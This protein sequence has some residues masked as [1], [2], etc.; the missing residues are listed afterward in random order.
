MSNWSNYQQKI[1]P[2]F[3]NVVQALEN[4]YTSQDI[5]FDQFNTQVESQIESDLQS[6]SQDSTFYLEYATSILNYANKVPVEFGTPSTISFYLMEKDKAHYGALQ[7]GLLDQYPDFQNLINEEPETLAQAI[8]GIASQGDFF[9]LFAQMLVGARTAT[10][11]DHFAL[12]YPIYED[13]E[14][15]LLM[16]SIRDASLSNINSFRVFNNLSEGGLASIISDSFGSTVFFNILMGSINNRAKVIYSQYGEGNPS[17]DLWDVYLSTFPEE[18]RTAIEFVKESGNFETV[19]QLSVVDFSVLQTLLNEEFFLL[20]APYYLVKSSNVT[21]EHSFSYQFN[22]K[23][24]R[25]GDSLPLSNFN[26]QVIDKNDTEFGDRLITTT[27][28]NLNGYFAVELNVLS[29]LLAPYTLD[30][31]FTSI[32]DGRSYQLQQNFDVSNDGLFTFNVSHDLEDNSAILNELVSYD[33]VVVIPPTLDSFLAT[34]N[35]N[36]LQDVR[37]F[38][39]LSGKET[40]PTGTLSIAQRIDAHSNLELLHVDL[41]KEDYLPV[42][43]HLIDE[44]FDSIPKIIK[45]DRY[46]F[47]KK[48]RVHFSS[49]FKLGQYDAGKIY[50][51]ADGVMSYITTRLN[52]G[53]TDRFKDFENDP[54]LRA[55]LND[56]KSNKCNCEDCKAGTSPLAYLTD[57]I[58]YALKNVSEV[59]LSDTLIDGLTVVNLPNGKKKVTFEGS[60][61]IEV[62]GDEKDMITHVTSST[63]KFTL[64][65]LEAKFKHP[66]AQLPANCDSVNKKVCQ[67]RVCIEVLWTH[68]FNPD[69]VSD[70]NDLLSADKLKEIRLGTYEYLLSEL[71]TSYEEIRKF[72]VSSDEEKANLSQRLGIKE[73]NL[74]EL[75]L[76]YS[77]ENDT[78]GDIKLEELFGYRDTTRNYLTTDEGEDLPNALVNTPKSRIATFKENY[79]RDQFHAGDFPSVPY[80]ALGKAKIDPDIIFPSDFRV[81]DESNPLFALWQKRFDWLNSFASQ[82]KGLKKKVSTFPKSK[83]VKLQVSLAE[84]QALGTFTMTQDDS[85]PVSLTPTD[86]TMNALGT[87]ASFLVEETPPISHMPGSTVSFDGETYELGGEE[88]VDVS[89]SNSE[90]S[91]KKSIFEK[92]QEEYTYTNN[93]GDDFFITPWVSALGPGD[94][95]DEGFMDFLLGNIKNHEHYENTLV[96]IQTNFALNEEQFLRLYDLFDID[97]KAKNDINS[98]RLSAEEIEELIDLTVTSVKNRLTVAW[99]NEED[100]LVGGT[101]PIDTENFWEAEKDLVEGES[102][103]PH[104]VSYFGETASLPLIDPEEINLKDLP[105]WKIGKDAVQL[106]NE[107]QAALETAKVDIRNERLT[108]SESSDLGFSK[109]LDFVYGTDTLTQLNTVANNLSSSD[110][111]ISAAATKEIEDDF[112]MSLEEFTFIVALKSKCDEQDPVNQPSE[113]EWGQ[114]FSTLLG[115]YKFLRLIENWKDDEEAYYLANINKCWKLRKPKLRKWRGGVAVRTQWVNELKTLQRQPIIDPYLITP[116]YMKGLDADDV[117]FSADNRVFQIWDNRRDYLEEKRE[118]LI[119]DLGTTEAFQHINTFLQNELKITANF[120]VNSST[121]V[122]FEDDLTNL[123]ERQDNG[124]SI[125][126]ALKQLGFTRKSF[127]HLF[128]VREL[129]KLDGS[130]L[131]T[132]P[133]REEIANLL[134]NI[135]KRRFFTLWN[136][137]EELD[138]DLKDRYPFALSPDFFMIP[139]PQEFTFPPLKEKEKPVYLFNNKE[140]KK[141]KRTLESKERIW[142]N[143]ADSLERMISDTENR[144][145]IP[146]RDAIIEHISKS[147]GISLE[148]THDFITRNLLIDSKSTS[149]ASTTRVSQAIEA[150]QVLLWGMHN[151]ILLD[152]PNIAQLSLTAPDFDEEWKWLGSYATWRS[153]MFVQLYPENILLPSLK[154]NQSD[155]YQ[156]ALKHLSSVTSIKSAQQVFY[157]YFE[158]LNDVKTMELLGNVRL[159]TKAKVGWRFNFSGV[160][161]SFKRETLPNNM[162]CHF[163]IGRG[164]ETESFYFRETHIDNSTGNIARQS[165][166]I[167]IPHDI[168]G[169]YVGVDF[170]TIGNERNI[171]LFFLED[172]QLMITDYD[173]RKNR[174]TEYRKLEFGNLNSWVR[175]DLDVKEYHIIKNSDGNGRPMIFYYGYDMTQFSNYTGYN[176]TRNYSN[177]K[178]DFTYEVFMMNKEGKADNLMFN[179][180]RFYRTSDNHTINGKVVKLEDRIIK[181]SYKEF[182]PLYAYFDHGFK[183]GN[184]KGGALRVV[185]RDMKQGRVGYFSYFWWGLTYSP[186]FFTGVHQYK[187]DKVHMQLINDNNVLYN[188]LQFVSRSGNIVDSY[189]ADDKFSQGQSGTATLASGRKLERSG[190][191]PDSFASNSFVVNFDEGEKLYFFTKEGENEKIIEF[192][193]QPSALIPT[194]SKHAEQQI[195]GI[196]LNEEYTFDVK[197]QEDIAGGRDRNGRILKKEVSKKSEHCT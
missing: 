89:T 58:N 112:K 10:I 46:D 172:N 74:E 6:I 138:T 49:S 109:T 79:L 124:F 108:Y 100:A 146:T 114:F 175:K 155:Q 152:E 91:G 147:E 161:T 111:T 72:R 137:Q 26:V 123:K 120:Q 158:Y 187:N 94:V 12:S 18:K 134:V 24:L 157:E 163:N 67:V 68:I 86:F 38:G 101:L 8:F 162:N 28:T 22:G 77:E 29:E 81:P 66:F 32:D 110:T 143:N 133:E 113:E 4:Y 48:M 76:P 191:N 154:L 3:R 87:E 62:E 141:W 168:K 52:Q 104:N 145:L 128:E 166:W 64:N 195:L 167:K 185:F 174:W 69:T 78:I 164:N 25:T 54:D 60:D 1:S 142:K 177:L 37:D 119:N 170:C 186:H 50:E 71:G 156:K 190:F 5:S 116:A 173:F 151:N 23:L 31:K 169:K 43:K 27:S 65:E 102:P 188:N 16:N 196:P 179:Y 194:Y 42:S 35:L 117:V 180:D 70:S 92:I 149:C 30:Y 136:L 159:A 88:E 118:A 105:D 19:H 178:T 183:D 2:G 121:W 41:E 135:L 34:H 47:I 107:R 176:D 140:F 59:T 33:D 21:E 182:K 82:L 127:E 139:P 13:A 126:K 61:L 132:P 98:P 90:E 153:A 85:T 115:P 80:S 150:L 148:E 7:E 181:D 51:Q 160:N 122:L 11:W 171:H 184:Y 75:N 125:K 106:F 56:L 189:V 165:E 55:A 131:L 20:L 53:L 99:I 192:E 103:F 84:A 39:G 193:A 57:L 96:I 144:F 14:A 130:I 83:R 36:T 15:E 9:M 63:A 40:L 97:R 45:T 17:A 93:D 197:Y 73:E 129:L 44:G 95:I